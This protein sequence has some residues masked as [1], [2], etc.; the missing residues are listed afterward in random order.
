MLKR[1]SYIG[2]AVQIASV[3]ARYR[4]LFLL[5]QWQIA[6]ICCAL[7]A[8]LGW[9]SFA[10]YGKSR[11]ERL[12]RAFQSLGPTFIKLGQTL[13]TRSDLLGEE[14]AADLAYLRDALPPFSGNQA[15][16]RIE[17][18]LNMQ[19]ETLF[20]QFDTTPVAAASIAQVHKA[21][22]VA[23]KEW[24]VKVVR[25]EVEQQLHFDI[26]FFR[27]LAEK[28]TAKERLKRFDAH[29]LVD[30]FQAM[31]E[32]E[33]DL[34]NEAAAS[35]EL[36]SMLQDE[37]DIVI[38][39]VN[40]QRTS[41]QV[42]VMEWCDGIRIDDIAAL[43]AAG[44]ES[45]GLLRI[46]ASSFFTQVYLNGFFHADMHPG[47]VLVDAHG[48]IVLL[49]FGIMGR[50]DDEVRYYLARMLMGLLNK[51]YDDVA[52]MHVRAGMLPRDANVAEFAQ[53]CRALGEPVYGMEQ[54][55][56]SLASM[57]QQMLEVAE[58]F[59]LAPQPHLLLLHKALLLVEGNAR[60]LD[61]TQNFWELAR[62][63]AEKW[64]K[65]HM[66][67]R[68]KL[69][70]TMWE[71]KRAQRQIMKLLDAADQA[72]DLVHKDGIKLHPSTIQS[73]VQQR[74]KQRRKHIIGWLS[75]ALIAAAAGAGGAIVILTWL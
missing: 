74:A 73:F 63:T 2:R 18:A 15:K 54:G 55:H 21:T 40:W 42:M 43:Q 26:S 29:Q 50:L 36:R 9:F 53:A 61:S 30:I 39:E 45:T 51:D 28:I 23:G 52:A 35:D 44:H 3:L 60:M 17:R 27:Y 48:R 34:R 65:K 13:S 7:M 75:H 20:A 71:L 37:A 22:D 6:P 66:G 14:V 25:P 62:P 56:I 31:V 59:N 47:N 10:L 41:K 1:I 24:A 5:R 4:A 72:A 58:R 16:L 8:P 32:K 38:P 49:D 67:K 64:A 12:A 19:M 57:L 33:L 46:L 69:S 70:D 11:G 68:A